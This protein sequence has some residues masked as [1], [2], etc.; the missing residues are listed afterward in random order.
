MY[1]KYQI[2]ILT[3]VLFSS[4]QCTA[5]QFGENN[6]GIRGCVR[7][8]L[9]LGSR[10][11][12]RLRGD[13]A[14]RDGFTL[15]ESGLEDDAS[16]QW[17]SMRRRLLGFGLCL[18]LATGGAI[19]YE[20]C[21]K[22]LQNEAAL[23]RVP[24]EF[25]EVRCA[26]NGACALHCYGNQSF[27]RSEGKCGCCGMSKSKGAFKGAVF[28]PSLATNWSNP[29]HPAGAFT[30]IVEPDEDEGVIGRVVCYASSA[31]ALHDGFSPIR[32]ERIDDCDRY[33]LHYRCAPADLSGIGV[34]GGFVD[35]QEAA[36]QPATQD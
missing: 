12:D 31:G 13:S 32:C 5:M 33:D 9:G 35:V 4:F 7:A 6:D 21:K 1:K 17:C 10:I 36:C 14:R 20:V 11:V 22:P 29:H 2:L 28:D 16:V 27:T 3:M 23:V 8:I 15:A 24:W 18:L 25:M 30:A 19:G 26:A 34:F